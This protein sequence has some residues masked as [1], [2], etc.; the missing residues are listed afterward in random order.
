ML[1]HINDG[2]V[3]IGGQTVLEHIDFEIRGTEKIAVV[4]RNGAG[5]TTLLR[6][7]AGELS[8]DRDDKRNGPGVVVSRSVTIGMLSQT[9][10]DGV[11]HTVEAE[12]MTCGGRE[13]FSREQFE[14]EREFDRLFT[15]LGFSLEDKKKSIAEFSG[16]ERTKI[17]LIRLLMEK[18]DILLLDEPTNHLD[19][20]TVEWLEHYMRM[21]PKAVV[22]VSHDRFFLDRT[23]DVVYEL[24]GGRLFRYAG[25]YTHYRQQKLKNIALGYKAWER[26]QEEIKRLEALI[27]RFK[28]KPKKAA[29]ARSRKKII[30]RMEKVE[31]PE[32]DDAH[33]FTGE[34]SPLIS[35]SKWVFEC[36]H[37]KIGYDR[38]LLELGLR[39]RRGQKIGILGPNGA[40]KTTFLKT[41]AGLLPALSG[42]QS[43]GNMTTIGYFDQHSAAIHSE[44]TVAE[45]FHDLFPALT[46]KEVRQTLGAYLFGGKNASKKVDALSGGEKARLVLAE[47]LQS[48]PN[49]LILDEPTN[50]MDIAAKETL[51]SAF[52]A[53]TGTILFVS[54]DRY[55]IRQVAESVLI[56]EN[57]TAMYYPFGYEH[58]VERKFR[59]SLGVP[60]SVQMRAEEQALIAGMRAVPRAERHS[61]REISTDEAY[62]DW[63]L[64]LSREQ[65]AAAENDVE[66]LWG[67]LTTAREEWMA[68]EAFWNESD[69]GGRGTEIDGVAVDGSAEAD[70]DGAA[71]RGSAETDCDGAADHGTE[72]DG[73]VGAGSA[74]LAGAGAASDAAYDRLLLLYN[75]ALS[76]WQE[77]CLQWYDIYR[78]SSEGV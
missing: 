64:R 39:I 62:F 45:H 27:E 42:R 34:I 43:L 41:V 30:E 37:M 25:N 32:M 16:G 61:L 65:L 50:H 57:G 58:Y 26:Q 71:G 77:Q 15:G 38:P 28:H 12:L 7:L 47:L 63:Q 44:K 55:F 48:R 76:I 69:A 59:E 11:S 68:S 52:K 18:P 70:Y 35:G 53:Y 5:K 31:K 13:A 1:F 2:T 10:L 20:E 23:A 6:L 4:G 67:Q 74:E 66:A 78:A 51:E 72:I 60:M 56:F 22:M 3:S 14:Y 36:E 73:A 75:N 21:Y 29:F 54:H 33:L 19:M 40:G 8:L 46:E 9:A 49:F 17:A 24:S